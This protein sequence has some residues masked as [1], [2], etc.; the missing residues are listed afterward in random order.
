MSLTDPYRKPV[1]KMEATELIG[2]IYHEQLQIFHA[3]K[4]ALELLEIS[5][6]EKPL[7]E[8]EINFLELL[9]KS[10]VALGNIVEEIG[11]WL[12]SRA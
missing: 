5:L 6:K 4:T 10:N 1:N 3:Q 2:L 9:N 11:G 7:E 8:Q 12:K